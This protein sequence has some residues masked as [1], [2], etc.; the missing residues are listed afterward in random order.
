MLNI[1][2]TLPLVAGLLSFSFLAPVSAQTTQFTSIY[3]FGDSLSDNGNVYAASNNTFPPSPYSD[4]R[5]SNGPVWVEQVATTLGIP[6]YDYAYGGATTGT[7][8]VISQ[9]LPGLTQE[10]QEFDYY[11]PKADPNALYTIWI[12]AND[13]LPTSTQYFTPY[14][15]PT[16]PLDNIAAAIQSLI[17]SGAQNF[18]IVDLPDLGAIPETNTMQTASYYTNLTNEFNADLLPTIESLGIPSNVTLTELDVDSLLN[19]ILGNPSQYGFTDVT[20]ACLTTSS[21]CTDPN[22]YLFW[23][24]LHPTTTADTIIAQTAITDITPVPEP[25]NILGSCTAA[26]FG[27]VLRWKKRG[28]SVKRDKRKD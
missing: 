17:T 20:D 7:A 22:Q 5:F 14:T 10:I 9:L 6:L 25:L 28:S 26:I 4:G 1:N 11:H 16:V 21:L 18:L 27:V 3:A 2:K 13:F 12:G 19:N 15:T 8:N 23:D 24:Q